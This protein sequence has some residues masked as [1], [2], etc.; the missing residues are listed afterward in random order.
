MDESIQRTESLKSRAFE[1]GFQAVGICPAAPPHGLAHLDAWLARGFDGEMGYIRRRRPAYEHPRHVLPQVASVVVLVSMYQTAEPHMPATGQGRVARYAVSG[2]D[3]HDILRARLKC[4]ADF[5]RDQVPGAHVRGAVDTAPLLERE[6]AQLAGLGWQGKNTLLLHPRLGSW[7]FLSE[8]LTSVRLAYDLPFVTDHC[9]TC[10]ACLDV[11]PTDAFV[12][13]TVLDATRCISYL[14][15]EH[16]SQIPLELR[17][18]LGDWLF[19]CDLCQE[20][21]PWNRKPL[22][23]DDALFAPAPAF[24][25]IDLVPLFG[26]GADEFERRFARTPLARPGRAGLLRNAAIVLGNQ[27]N[28]SAVDG[29]VRGLND[30]ETIVRGA[31]AWALGQIGTAAAWEA[32]HRRL[33]AEQDD[34]VRAE[35]AMA[36]GKS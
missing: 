9:G 29:L 15:I 24:D 30:S 33:E 28:A 36:L 4:L 17:A 7:F 20:V 25:P 13:P 31:A 10:R 11:C 26:L 18:P 2:N 19:G 27:Q 14:T 12:A 32:L 34:Q 1:L 21:C 3:Y 6:L 23:S 5:H 35:I 16:R 8:L 22:P